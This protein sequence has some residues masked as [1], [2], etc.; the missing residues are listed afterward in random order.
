MGGAAVKPLNL[1][2]ASISCDVSKGKSSYVLYCTYFLFQPDRGG[3]LVANNRLVGIL[4]VD[5]GGP[6]PTP[7]DL[8]TKVSAVCE[9]IVI[10]AGLYKISG[11]INW[12]E[13]FPGL[14]KMP[15]SFIVTYSNN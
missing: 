5:F 12:T 15:F 7:P 13:T 3:P 8:Y 4:A 2:R 14:Q 11:V 1:L 9:W 10:N 6:Q